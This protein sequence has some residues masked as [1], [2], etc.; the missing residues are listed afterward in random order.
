[1]AV[2][3]RDDITLSR[4]DD[5]NGISLIV[6]Y[7]AIN[8]SSTTAPSSWTESEAMPP[9][10]GQPYLWGYDITTYTD[11]TTEETEKHVIGVRGDDGDITEFKK[12]AQDLV[13]SATQDL[14]DQIKQ[15]SDNIYQSMTDKNAA[16]AE[17]MTKQLDDYKTEVG[18][19]M[20]YGDSGLVLG[21]TGSDF[22][23]VIDNQGMYLKDGDTTVAYAANSQFYMPAAVVEKSLLLGKFMFT[24]HSNGD[25]GM[26]LIWTG[27]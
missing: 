24:P 11:G 1:M 22:N 2:K 8:D 25:G 5:G 13:D 21:A 12:V 16:L 4:V 9:T 6:H 27:G 14:Q 7:Y 10:E 17:S 20:R 23:T 3:A 19:Y 18:Q 15:E 26:S